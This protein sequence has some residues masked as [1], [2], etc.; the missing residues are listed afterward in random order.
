M[1]PLTKKQYEVLQ[2][3]KDY[4]H[5]HQYAPSYREI[6]QHFS[7]SS[8][9][10]VHGYIKILKEKG[11][12]ETKKQ[13]SRSLALLKEQNVKPVTTGLSLPLI[14]YISGGEPIGTFSKSLSFEVPHSLVE[15]PE[16]TYVLKVQGDN[17]VDELIADGDYLIVEA[18]QEAHSGET[19]VAMLNQHEIIVRKYFLEEAYVRLVS[20]S[21]HN[22]PLIL[23]EDD[24]MIQGV[25]VGLIRKKARL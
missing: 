2:Y 9:G 22:H 8:L 4:I 23:R 18:R 3:I 12:L 5:T 24:I 25:V 20:Q 17:L 21:P 6:M 16:A 7:F 11:V 15:I 13:S 14:G 19:V 1:K 10:T